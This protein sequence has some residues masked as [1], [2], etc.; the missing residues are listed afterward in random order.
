MMVKKLG[1]YAGIMPIEKPLDCM[2]QE[3]VMQ[4]QFFCERLDFRRRC[5]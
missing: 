3:S 1:M 5:T 2:Y 4:L